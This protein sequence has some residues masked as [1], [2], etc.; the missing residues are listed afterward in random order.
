MAIRCE[1]CMLELVNNMK[2]P[3]PFLKKSK[4]ETA[5]YLA[6]L[7]T[8]EK[9]GAV[10]LFESEGKVKIIN[11]HEEFFPASIDTISQEELI[12][13]VDK[14][15]SRA[16]EVLPPNIETH[17]TVF[18]VK[19]SWLDPE[20][21]KITKEQLTKLKKVCDSLDLTP[22]GF[23]VTTEAIA[24]LIQEEE[25]APLSAVLA[26]VGHKQIT[27]TLL[28][29]GKT[30]E[31]VQGP[32]AESAAESVDKLLQHF[33]V[34]VL[35]AR[36]VLFNSK[37]TDKVSQQFISHQ[38][39]KG[40]PF[41]HVPQITVLPNGFDA[42][43]VTFGAATQLGFSLAIDPHQILPHTLPPHHAKTIHHSEEA[44]TEHE[45]LRE[46]EKETVEPETE[47]EET[48]PPH[49]VETTPPLSGDNFGFVADQDV[50]TAPLPERKV[51]QTRPEHVSSHEPVHHQTHHGHTQAL[52]HEPIIHHQTPDEPTH[53][54]PHSPTKK[55]SLLA[56]L[57]TLT[58]PKLSGG[59]AL[60][61]NK[62]VWIIVAV[63]VLLCALG[64]GLSYFYVNNVTASIMLTLKPKVANQEADV[65]FSTTAPSDFSKDIIAAKS[66]TTSLPGTLT[67]DATGKKDV[68]EKAKGKVTIY[69]SSDESVDL[70]SG[71]ILKSSNGTSFLLDKDVTVASAEGD[72][73]SG[74]K[75]GTTDATVTAKDPGTESNLP[76]NTKFSLGGNLL[77][78]KNDDAFSGGS[79]KTVTVVSK[80]DLANLRTELLQNLEDKGLDQ[81]TK[82]AD[83]GETVLPLVVTTTVD[84]ATYD[85]KVGDEAKKVKL[86]GSVQFTGMA[87]TN[88]ELEQYTKSKLKDDQEK[89]IS[90]ADNSI[91]STVSDAKKKSAK[92]VTAT[93]SL[94]AGLLPNIDKTDVLRS[95]EDKSLQEANDELAKLPQLEKS[96]ITFS[97]NIPFLPNLFPKLPKTINVEISANE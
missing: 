18:G 27:L 80:D 36:I 59:S 41:L 65:T 69:N 57:P 62:I 17:K 25:G 3:I 50:A 39:N 94:E 71:T 35:P 97:P 20:T 96:E 37:I 1:G 75:P 47:P 79:K 78:A 61:K 16:E 91:K 68:G 83:T 32:I 9:A 6:L 54:V 31:T 77:A 49:H 40:L 58:L 29:G 15:I 12:S 72:I 42:K 95:V 73:F 63:L 14:A 90:F 19:E 24:N 60:A 43:A 38:W 10:I 87:Y 23:M 67:L 64:G 4:A 82:Q 92:E 88:D 34:A 28:R 85:K 22:I 66:V 21:K 84:K 2:L 11:S 48:M 13:G 55:A 45:Q 33:T 81:L 86:T 8:D 89:N 46:P 93:V 5:Y 53:A 70:D 74:T 7:L 52:H 26:E 44:E 76:S 51:P 30:A 56:G